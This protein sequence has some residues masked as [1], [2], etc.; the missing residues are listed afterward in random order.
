M[1]ISEKVVL[2][3]LYLRNYTEV[4]LFIPGRDLDDAIMEYELMQEWY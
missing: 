2:E 3:V 1:H 4:V